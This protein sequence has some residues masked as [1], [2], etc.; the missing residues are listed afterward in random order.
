M[1]NRLSDVLDVSRDPEDAESQTEQAHRQ[2]EEMIITLE[3]PPG[4]SV[5]EATLSARIGISR[6]PVRMAIKRLE[7]QGLITCVPRKGVFIRQLRVEDELAVLE[8]RRPLER[9][10]ACKAARS[11]TEAQRQTLRFCVECM[12]QA[13]LAGDVRRYLHFDSECDRIIYE[14]SRN[15]F[16]I[17]F[18]ELLYTHSRRFWVAYSKQA[19]WIKIARLHEDMMNAVADGDEARTGA[20]SEA[21]IA[22]LEDFCKSVIGLA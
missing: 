15:P 19:D 6:T 7:H 20:G 21:L 1:N 8:V 13:A 10:L 17:D 18:V 11:T 14:T 3:L 9:M 2:I 5:S 16:A 12:V 4:A 22:Y